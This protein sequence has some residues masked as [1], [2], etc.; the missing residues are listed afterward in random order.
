[1]FKDAQDDG[2]SSWPVWGHEEKVINLVNLVLECS[3]TQSV[4]EAEMIDK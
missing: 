2:W 1:V 4:C 3:C